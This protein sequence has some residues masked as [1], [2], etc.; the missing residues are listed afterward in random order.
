MKCNW[1]CVK[2]KRK[3]EKFE[4]SAE[5]LH[6]KML[7]HDYLGPKLIRANK[8]G[9]K[10]DTILRL[11]AKGMSINAIAETVR[12]TRTTIAFRLARVLLKE[13]WIKNGHY[14]I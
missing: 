3:A 5:L 8:I 10:D 7:V 14:Q 11:A 13:I 2:D 6:H 4:T 9:L 12:K 1:C